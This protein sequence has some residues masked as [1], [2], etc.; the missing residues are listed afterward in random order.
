MCSM[1]CILS[2]LV[3][4]TCSLFT[5]YANISARI[6]NS[7][8]DFREY[9]N[10]VVISVNPIIVVQTE[11][12]DS[13]KF[14]GRFAVYKNILQN[15]RLIPVR[16]AMVK[17]MN[18]LNNNV[19]SSENQNLYAF[20]QIAGKKI[21]NNEIYLKKKPDRGI[22]LVAGN[23]FNGLSAATGRFEYYFSKTMGDL[24]KPG[25]PGKGL[26]SVKVYFEGGQK[27][28]SYLFNENPEYFTFTRGTF[29]IN[30][31]YYP[32]PYL[33]WGPFLG[34]GMEFA[35]WENSENFI[36]TNFTEFGARLGVNLFHNL[37]IIGSASYY[38][39]INSVLMN[40]GSN[41]IDPDFNYTETFPDRSNVGFNIALR[42]ML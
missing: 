21:N 35:R 33:H 8:K 2:I 11:I 10:L 38:Y 20:Y 37:Q 3:I 28:K 18:A 34:Y 31:D 12:K 32:L 5:T 17:S 1:K 16:I 9:A 7:S 15:D 23:T 24:V 40:S 42:L 30:K 22:N 25:K 6:Q 13:L 14:E 29:G 39:L 26:T 41:V 19:G 27:K 36:S 4:C